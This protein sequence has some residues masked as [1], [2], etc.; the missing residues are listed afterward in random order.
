MVG[1]A[2]A[3]TNTAATAAHSRCYCAAMSALSDATTMAAA[4][5]AGEVSSAE[6]VTEAID[7][8]E[9]LNPT[10]NFM[11]SN[12][13]EAA[14]EEAQSHRGNG[15]FAG[16]PFLTKDLGCETAGEPSW[17]GNTVARGTDHRA[18]QDSH[19]ALL[20]RDA[21][22]INLGR[23]NTPEFGSIITTEPVANGPCRNPW[24]TDHST[25]GSSGGS[26]AAVS[27]GVVPVAHAND[28]GGSIRIPA[29]ECGLVGL[30]P[31]R[32]RVSLGPGIGEGWGG[33]AADLVVSRT[34][35]DTAAVLDAVAKPMP[36]DPYW[37]SPPSQPFVSNVDTD[38]GQLRICLVAQLS[39]AMVHHECVEAVERAG[40]ALEELGHHISTEPLPLLD[41]ESY[42]D[43]LLTL[44][45]VDVARDVDAVSTLLGRPI[46]EEDVEISNRLMAERGR[47]V[48][49]IQYADALDG[50]HAFGRRLAAYWDPDQY[51]LVVT[52]TLAGP[53][54]PI[55]WLTGPEASDRMGSLLRFTA[56]L[57]ASGQPAIS[58]PLHWT[59]DALPVGVQCI[60]KMNNEATLISVASQLESTLP[61]ADKIP[62]IN[63]TL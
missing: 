58:L 61:W 14:I 9:R 18:T 25:G 49:A 16:V 1:G 20:F 35:R 40:A 59:A 60:A 41:D 19:L 51:D 48:T 56:Q 11:V 43:D 12:R 37:S 44:I 8:I 62:P 6:L 24:N 2:A 38:P 55:G 46:G 7:A 47:T 10:L 13:F 34:V 15:L 26:A 50:M 22:F 32:G 63:A 31:S 39:D 17:F 4:I 36:G 57:N 21:G 3:L 23:T 45:S 52:P 29:S 42:F 30:K 28:G 5:R 27:A 54:P 53:P 33:A